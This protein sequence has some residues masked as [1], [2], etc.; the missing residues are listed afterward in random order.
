MA[1]ILFFPHYGASLKMIDNPDVVE[2]IKIAQSDI[3]TWE[4]V[5]E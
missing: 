1:M 4:A 2:E 3:M 5:R